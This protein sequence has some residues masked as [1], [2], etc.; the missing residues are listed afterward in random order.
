MDYSK[1]TREELIQIIDELE[2]LNNELL[3]EKEQEVNLNFPWT[4]N[5][6]HWY[7]NIKTGSVIF[8]PLK[9]MA[10]GYTVE[11]LPEKVS[12]KF[13]TDKLHPEDYEKTMGAMKLNMEGKSNIYECEYRIQAK[14]KSW[15]WFYDRGKV[16]Q[17]DIYG[18]PEFAVGIV[19]DITE[20]KERE[21]RLEENN[22][23]LREKSTKDELT[24][25]QN[26]RGI[27]E[28]LENRINEALKN[29]T[30]LSI[31]MFDIDKFKTLNDTKGHTFG[32]KVLKEVANIAAENMRGLD[33]IGRYGGEEFLAIFPNTNRENAFLVCERIRKCVE[34]FDFG[35]EYKV[36]ISGGV[37]SYNKDGITELINK[38][39]KKLYEAK[40]SGRNRIEC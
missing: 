33:S 20:Q 12:Y 39:D 29:R 1:Y 6:G 13:F 27:M 17:R 34:E 28:E 40:N 14:D 16:T 3:S 35:E 37:A 31:A 36:T 23:I 5:L 15:K 10:L 19:F 38:A 18:N 24:K 32:D 2:K 9:I 7:F 26:R 22:K 21:F 25:I 8:N 30:L 4:G 11:E